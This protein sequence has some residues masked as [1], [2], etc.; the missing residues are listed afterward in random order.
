MQ[1][2]SVV[3][4]KHSQIQ[5][6]MEPIYPYNHCLVSLETLLPTKGS[7]RLEGPLSSAVECDIR[8]KP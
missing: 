4:K 6:A 5:S 1:Y 3:Q 2:L 8:Q 7:R